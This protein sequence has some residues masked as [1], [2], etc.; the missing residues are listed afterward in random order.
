[1]AGELE[2]EKHFE[3]FMQIAASTSAADALAQLRNAPEDF[4]V[5]EDAEG[6]R[7]LIQ[8]DHLANLAG[9][10]DHSLSDLLDQLP[11]PVVVD[12]TMAAFDSDDLKQVALLLEQTTAPGLIIYQGKDMRGVISLESIVEALPLDAI[13]P[14]R[15]KGDPLTPARVY[16]CSTCGTSR[17]LREGGPPDCPTGHGLMKRMGS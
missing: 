5:V 13:P 7:A 10:G 11:S 17:Y 2:L 12:A 9:V 1:M 8:A 4:A 15:L 14:N 3:P 16:I 6:P